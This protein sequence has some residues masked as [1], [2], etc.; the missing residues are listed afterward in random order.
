MEKIELGEIIAERIFKIRLNERTEEV[1]V[2]LG[3]PVR[4][5]DSDDYLAPFQIK[6]IGNEKVRYSGGIDSFQSIQL[7]MRMI[8]YELDALSQTLGAKFSWE[9]DE[10]GSLGF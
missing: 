8:S 10:E 5:S 6:G 1:M 3:K 9:G 7:A 2:L 4:F